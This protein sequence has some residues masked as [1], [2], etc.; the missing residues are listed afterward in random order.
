MIIFGLAL[1]VIGLVFKFHKGFAHAIFTN[2]LSAMNSTSVS[3]TLG[4]KDK[5]ALNEVTN[6][7]A[8]ILGE[9][10]I[11][12]I[13]AG[14]IVLIFSVPGF[15]GAC[16]RSRCM[17][18]IYILLIAFAA[19]LMAGL[20]IFSVVGKGKFKAIGEKKVRFFFKNYNNPNNGNFGKVFPSLSKLFKCCGLNS[21]KDF[22]NHTYAFM[23]YQAIVPK[24]CCKTVNGTVLPCTSNPTS[25]NSYQT[26]C[27]TKFWMLFEKN[28]M[29]ITIMLAIAT[30]AFLGIIVL[31]CCVVKYEN[32]KDK[33]KDESS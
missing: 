6:T 11:S 28:G 31:T 12:T 14:L 9:V 33:D 1:F 8:V 19:V 13:I 2:A 15:V 29:K 23:G 26:G 25:S 24:E 5:D 27:F 10:A 30:V 16:R 3:K 20:C 7:V 21:P 32:S 18:Y 17:L 22:Q 4:A